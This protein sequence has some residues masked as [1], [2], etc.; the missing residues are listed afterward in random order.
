MGVSRINA[1]ARAI[2]K[3]LA[4]RPNRV[5]VAF[6]A[7]II[8]GR[9]TMLGFA[10]DARYHAAIPAPDR[11][12]RGFAQ[13]LAE[14]PARPFEAVDRTIGAA[15]LIRRDADAGRYATAESVHED[16]RRLQ[17]TS[18]ALIAIGWAN[19][20]G[21]VVAHSYEAAPPRPNIAQL[22]HFI[23]HPDNPAA[24]L[25]GAPPFRSPAT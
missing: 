11:P 22:P 15:E 7:F 23:T 2:G 20:A 10:L 24:A 13:V 5:L 12:G 17:Q 19:A 8:I 18:R 9:G 14:H 4:S 21:D 16:L 25:F 1:L 3:Y 6:A